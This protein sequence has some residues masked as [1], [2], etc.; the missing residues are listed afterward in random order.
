MPLFALKPEIPEEVKKELQS[1]PELLQKLLYYRGITDAAAADIFLNPLYERD[2]HDP[3]LMLDMKKAAER[4]VLA[5]KNNEKICVYSDYDADGIPGGVILHDLLKKIGYENFFNYIPD[6]HF[7]GYGLSVLAIEEVASRGAQVV[8]TVDCGIVDFA[9]TLR[10]KELGM[11]LIITDHHLPQGELPEAYAVV[12]PKREGDIYPDNMLCGA[13]MAFK[14]A[15]AILKLDRFGIA[16][17]WEKWL[18]DM[19]GLSTIADMVP[20]QKENRAI[21]HFGL[22]VLRKSPRPGL[23]QMLR[24]MKVEQKSLTEDDISFMIVPRINAASR[25][26]K[27]MKAF[28]LLKTT[29]ISEAEVLATHLNQINDERKGVVAG[30][31]KE[32]HHKSERFA[33]KNIIVV[34]NPTWRPGLLGLVANSVMEH[35]GKSVF[36]WGRDG[37]ECIKGSCRSDGSINVVELMRE[38]PALIEFGGHKFAGGFSVENEKIHF[39]EN[40]IEL[41]YEKVRLS[42]FEEE[43]IEADSKLTISEIN[44]DNYRLVEKMAPFGEG[45]PKPVFLLEDVTCSRVSQFGKENNHLNVYLRDENTNK[46]VQAIAFFK[47]Q[48]DFQKVP[49]AGRK[50][51]MAAHFEKSNFRGFP[52]LRL[53]IVDLY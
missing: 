51:N 25:M 29:D 15:Q 20:L 31:V 49:E 34:G 35:Y 36:I 27:P 52:E 48:S 53:R 24:K 13:G 9:P 42:G 5:I 44:F 30:M 8:V 37:M 19:A 47:N 22:K 11:D 10:A 28:E 21:A 7:E 32:I 41:A 6:R 46:E 26:D 18:L 43:K 39:L 14:L 1:Y 38:T 2:V 23:L 12:N 45:N 3:F 17:G 16:E 4:V 40:E 50:I 33:A